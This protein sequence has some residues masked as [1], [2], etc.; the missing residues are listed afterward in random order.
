[1]LKIFIAINKEVLNAFNII[2]TIRKAS[3]IILY[4]INYNQIKNIINAIDFIINIIINTLI[5]NL[6]S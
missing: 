6:L 4:F 1:M 2:Y 5:I 3:F